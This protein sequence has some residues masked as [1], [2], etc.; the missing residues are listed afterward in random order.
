MIPSL[1]AMSLQVMLHR[2]TTSAPELVK[3]KI[4]SLPR[5]LSVG[6]FFSGS[7]CFSKVVMELEAA[8]KELHPKES[9]GIDES[10]FVSVHSLLY[11][12]I[13]RLYR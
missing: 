7:G 1:N 10:W 2:L 9:E 3:Q 4:R 6:D 11:V 13:L 5:K 8:M 12:F